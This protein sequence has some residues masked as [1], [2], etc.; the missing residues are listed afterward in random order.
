MAKYQLVASH[1]NSNTGKYENEQVITMPGYDLN[2]LIGIDRFTCLHT[3]DE[4]LRIIRQENNID[5]NINTISIR[6]FKNAKAN[7]SYYQIVTNSQIIEDV[8]DDIEPKQFYGVKNRI[9]DAINKNNSAFNS[10]KIRL[11][12]LLET[13]NLEELDRLI[14]K[15]SD[16][17][18][19]INRYLNSYY[20]NEDEK[21]KDLALIILEFSR[22]K[23]F[24]GW[25]VANSK[26]YTKGKNTTTIISSKPKKE[27]KIEVKSIEQHEI[28]Y[29][30]NFEEKHNITYIEQ[31]TYDYNTRDL[32]DD[33]EEFI[34]PDELEQMG[35]KR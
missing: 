18:H 21:E 24:R 25:V 3:K 19:L 7:P 31:T 23:T 15:N 11:I 9:A 16:L 30:E 14:H 13:R 26:T 35:Y 10:E 29:E 4:L 17:K 6:Y 5:S 1:Y 8:L 2:S 33:K 20:D 12:Q 34:E 27:K 28:E 22:Y 32:D